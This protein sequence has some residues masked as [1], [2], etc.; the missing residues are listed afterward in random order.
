VPDGDDHAAEV[1]AAVL[2]R[3]RHT[4]GGLPEVREEPAWVGVRWQV[5]RRTFAH[6]LTIVGGHPPAYARAAGTDGPACVVTVRAVG[7]ELDALGHAG[8]PFFRPV[9]G[10]TWGTGVVGVVVDDD[11]DWEEL[12]ELLTESYRLLAPATLRR[13]LP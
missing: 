7:P 9:W 11:T 8:P 6:V 2:S 10:T 1:P 5:R 3:L 13:Q 4:C 12:A